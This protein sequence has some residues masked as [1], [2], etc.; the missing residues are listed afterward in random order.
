MTFFDIA[1]FSVH[2]NKM[3]N[4]T[5]TYNK[6][7]NEIRKNKILTKNAKM[8]QWKH[9]CMG[10]PNKYKNRQNKNSDFFA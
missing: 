9:S 8:K 6:N 7:Y 2:M 10:F 1:I 4:K 5:E 3:Q